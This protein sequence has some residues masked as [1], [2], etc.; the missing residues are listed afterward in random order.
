M[1]PKLRKII[2]ISMVFT[3]SLLLAPPAAFGETDTLNSLPKNDPLCQPITLPSNEQLFDFKILRA[4]YSMDQ[5]DGVTIGKI[6]IVNLPVFN[7]NDPEENNA[8]YKFINGIHSPTQQYVVR[9]QLLFKEG[10]AL[11]PRLLTESE[12]L[13]RDNSYLSDAIVLPH[14]RCGD[15]LDLVVVARDLW[16]LLPKLYFSRKGGNNKYGLILEDENVF[17]T[18]NTMFLEFIKDRERDTTA[19]GYRTKQLFGTRVTLD[20]VYSDTTDGINKQL[21]ITRPFYALDTSWSLGAKINER[22]FEESL[23]AFNQDITTFDH[24]ENEY[25]LSA[26]YSQGLK[27]GFTRRYTFGF[28]GTEDIF[29]SADITATIPADRKLSYPWAQ[30]SIVE[31]NF[32][33]YRNLNAL[34]RTEDVPIGVEFSSSLGYAHEKF[35]SELSQWV[36]T[37]SFSD[38]PL[39][40]ERHLLKTELE[41]DGFWDRDINDF[42][43]TVATIELSYYWLMTQKQRVYVGLSYDHGENLA[44]DQLLQLGGDEGLRGYPSE[45]LLGD[46]RFLVNLEHR[47]FFNAHYLNLFRFAGVIFFDVG[48]TMYNENTVGEDSELLTST[49]VGIRINSSKTSITRIIH[50]DLAFP[51]NEKDELDDYQLR[52]TSSATF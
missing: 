47:Y 18:G 21:E 35:D 6:T 30:Y 7:L 31:D 1:S 12:R 10:D 16:T 17:G 49:G 27:E 46:R 14:Q 41:L 11:E 9:R 15:S 8:L 42:V 40:L 25:Q 39:T 29:E 38:F 34:Y 43:N 32:V 52:I 4:R 19:L 33:I 3:A 37:F 23:E 26:G 5:Y 36:F 50:L 22:T 48:Q 20:A 13:L 51:L 2:G 24:T 44:Q 28:T 45:Y